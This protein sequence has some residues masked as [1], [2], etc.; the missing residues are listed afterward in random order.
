MQYSIPNTKASLTIATNQTAHDTTHT[1]TVSE[2][3]SKS[4][5]VAKSFSGAYLLS[6]SENQKEELHLCGSLGDCFQYLLKQ[7]K[8]TKQANSSQ[9]KTTTTK[10]TKKNARD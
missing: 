9:V 8:S 6:R 1:F 3:R 2:G 7:A 10:G 5:W 4:K